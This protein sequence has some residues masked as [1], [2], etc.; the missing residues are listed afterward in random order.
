MGDVASQDVIKHA[1]AKEASE[2]IEVSSYWAARLY[3][4]HPA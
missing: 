2:N 1:A 3:D 4:M